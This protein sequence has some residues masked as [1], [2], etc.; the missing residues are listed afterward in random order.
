MAGN[1]ITEKWQYNTL[2]LTSYSGGEQRIKNLQ[3]PRH[4]VTYDYPAM[5]CLQAQ[6]M[7]GVGRLKQTV[8]FYV[9]M[10]HS[11]IYL[12]EKF[13]GGKAFYVENSS[14]YGL[15]NCQYIELFFED[16]TGQTTNKVCKLDYISEGIIGV[17]KAVNA[18]LPPTRAWLFPLKNCIAQPM[19]GLQYI[20]S[21]G[22]LVGISFEDLLDVPTNPTIPPSILNNYEN[23]VGWNMWNL[24]EVY[25]GKE[26]FL[27]T[28]RWVGDDGVQLSLTKNT[29]RLDTELG[30]FYYDL[31]NTRSYDVHTY[32][33]L[34]TCREEINNMTRFFKR[35]CGMWKSFWMPTWVNDIEV[36][37]DLVAGNSYFYAKWTGHADY[38]NTNGRTKKIII[39]TKDYNYHIYQILNYMQSTVNLETYTKVT[40]TDSIE[41]TIPIDNILMVSF[42]NLVRLDSD[43]LQINYETDACANVDLTFRE[44]DDLEG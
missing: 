7:R 15:F 6:W 1:S 43:E 29:N 26:M 11:P 9:P 38:Y 4:F 37:D 19:Q 16:D 8:P 10:W 13:N 14:I 23:Y 33:F 18:V 31:K 34:L 20:Y 28:P 21:N 2:I 22:S 36:E 39:F 40:L 27:H 42:L 3:N 25:I 41:E 12:S 44:V 35:V 24:P 30:M 5:D 32:K 17:K